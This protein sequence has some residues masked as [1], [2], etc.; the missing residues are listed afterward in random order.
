MALLDSRSM[1]RLATFVFLILVAPVA[2]A[3]STPLMLSGLP[4]PV[5]A[6]CLAPRL[7]AHC[8]CRC[9]SNSTAG[10]LD[11]PSIIAIAIQHFSSRLPPILGH[12]DDDDD[13]DGPHQVTIFFQRV[14]LCH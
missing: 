2:V 10:H 5:A 12:D 7:P 14:R 9:N 3:Q 4:G 6:S 11:G 13:D 8:N 1:F